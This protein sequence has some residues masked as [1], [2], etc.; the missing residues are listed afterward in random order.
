MDEHTYERTNPQYLELIEN[1][2][3]RHYS[4]IKEDEDD[5]HRSGNNDGDDDYDYEEID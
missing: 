3:E 5:L 1:S 4:D 2:Q